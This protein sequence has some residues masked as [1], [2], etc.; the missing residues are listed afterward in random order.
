M[1]ART[2]H[3]S[4]LRPAILQILRASGFHS[5]KPSVVDTLTDIASRYILLLAS[6]TLIYAHLN[7]NDSSPDITDVRMALV[8]CG[9][10][11]P[12]QTSS[13]EV[14]RELLRK[15]LSDVPER[16]GLREKEIKRRDGEDT[17]EIRDF[18]AWFSGEVHREIRRIAGLGQEE[19][20]IMEGMDQEKPDDYVTAMKTKHSKTGEEARFHGTIL[21][22]DLEIHARPIKIDGGPES[23]QQ[24][25]AQVRQKSAKLD[26]IQ[27]GNGYIA[28]GEDAGMTG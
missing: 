27:Q 23:I 10:L 20:L 3:H 21:G 7:H 4:L 11:T 1:S 28:D 24:W 16:N 19:G 5:A 25:H 17:S 9:L 12:T 6:K 15:P 14:W 18:V 26:T 13:E 2:L 22:K 8:D